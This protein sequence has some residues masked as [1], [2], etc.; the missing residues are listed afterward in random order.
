MK[1]FC[2]TLNNPIENGGALLCDW[3]EANCSYG[4][5]GYEVGK[6]GTPHWQGYAEL[7]NK[8]RDTTIYKIAKWH[9]ERRM[10]PQSKAITYCKK[11][12]NWVVWG[13]PTEQGYRSDLDSSRRLA[14]ESGM[15]AVSSTCNLQ[16]IRVAEKFLTYNEEPRDWMPQVIYIW[17]RSRTGKS[18]LARQLVAEHG[19]KDDVYCKNDNTKWWDGYDGQEA[20]IIDDFRDTW[21]APTEFLRIFDAY[22]CRVEYKGGYR[23]LRS[24]IMIITSIKA[25][26]TLYRNCDEDVNQF[27]GRLTSIL[28]YDEVCGSF[29]PDVPEV[30]GVILEPPQLDM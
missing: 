25:P 5:I 8:T 23:Q 15:R 19:L 18:R 1:N 7:K 17:G 4:V 16:Q 30:G 3:L 21:W 22:E 27:L 29:V 2:F 9:V 14:L 12:G 11:D 26:H 10:G 6:Q 28:K 20:I 13:K 24:R